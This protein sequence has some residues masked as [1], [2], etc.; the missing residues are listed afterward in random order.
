MGRDDE[1]G[2]SGIEYDL[3]CLLKYAIGTRLSVIQFSGGGLSCGSFELKTLSR[4]EKEKDSN[5]IQRTVAKSAGLR[6]LCCA[7]C[8]EAVGHS[9]NLDSK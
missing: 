3:Q 8:F 2:F 4:H 6:H 1:G 7:Y 9:F 5:H